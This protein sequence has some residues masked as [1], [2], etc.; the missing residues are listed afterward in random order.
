M[1]REAREPAWLDAAL[2]ELA[3]SDALQQAPPRVEQS[4]RAA[5]RARP[6]RRRPQE[7]PSLWWLAAAAAVL[8]TWGVLQEGAP[9]RAPTVDDVADAGPYLALVEG[10]PLDDLDAVQ[11]VRVRLPGSA[12]ARLGVPI[13]APGADPVEAQVI[14]GQDGVARAIRFVE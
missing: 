4:L 2:C 7:R 12:L 14:L 5:L 11:V 9:R 1:S 10:G 6:E 3:E 8:A 13:A